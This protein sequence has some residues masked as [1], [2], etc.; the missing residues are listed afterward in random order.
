VRDLFDGR[1]ARDVGAA[2]ARER[3]VQEVE[4]IV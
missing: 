4:G 3:I 2:A 1:F